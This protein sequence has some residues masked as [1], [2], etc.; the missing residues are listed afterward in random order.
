MLVLG[1]VYAVFDPSTNSFFP[2]CPIRWL[3]GVPCPGCGSQRAL[4]ALL[5]FDI[6]SALRYNF[7]LVIFIPGIIVLAIASLLRKTCPNFYRITHHYYVAYAAFAIVM[8]WWILRIIFHW[9]V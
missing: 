7:M 2:K 5:H 8:I 4:H 1:V 3:T 6:A 9:Y